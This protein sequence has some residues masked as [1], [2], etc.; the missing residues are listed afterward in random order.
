MQIFLS[1]SLEG[2]AQFVTVLFMFFF[3]LA[4]TYFTTRFIGNFQ[5]ARSYNKNF[6]AL[7]TF[8]VTN[9]KFLQLIRVGKRYFIISVGKDSVELISEISED[10][11]DFTKNDEDSGDKFLEL[12][13]NAKSKL[14]KR[15]DK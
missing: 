14:T 5:K 15:S 6:E 12:F 4:I 1:G 8:R 2:A 3:V 9:N 7:E 10:D 11:I 13:E